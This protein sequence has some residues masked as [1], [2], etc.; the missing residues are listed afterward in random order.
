MKLGSRA[1]TSVFTILVYFRREWR[2]FLAALLQKTTITTITNPYL[3]FNLNFEVISG[4]Y[5]RN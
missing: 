5:S 2:Y 4:S 1:R 3:T